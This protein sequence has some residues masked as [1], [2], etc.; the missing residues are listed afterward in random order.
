MEAP[1]CRRAVVS[2]SPAIDAPTRLVPF[3]TMQRNASTLAYDYLNADGESV[4]S[5]SYN[6]VS[7]TT[8][9]DSVGNY[10]YVEGYYLGDNSSK[11]VFDGLGEEAGNQLP[12][13]QVHAAPYSYLGHRRC[14]SAD[15]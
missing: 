2:S 12:E 1:T 14:C 6:W 11:P 10:L 4:R 5:F 15:A 3:T 9:N 8:Y 13:R 7:K